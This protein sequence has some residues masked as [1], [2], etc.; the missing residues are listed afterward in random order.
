[1][2]RV[3]KAK[4]TGRIR[5]RVK[6]KHTEEMVRI[7]KVKVTKSYQRKSVTPGWD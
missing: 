1:M 3:A 6:K 7:K 5:E 4:S 2:E